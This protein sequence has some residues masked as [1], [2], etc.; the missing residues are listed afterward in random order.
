MQKEAKSDA[1]LEIDIFFRKKRKEKNKFVIFSAKKKPGK[2]DRDLGAS[3][4]GSRGKRQR[5]AVFSGGHPSKY[6]PGPMLLNFSDR[7]ETGV[8]SMVRPLFLYW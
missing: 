2:P 1:F 5:N 8:F 6:L 3:R 4:T 7:T